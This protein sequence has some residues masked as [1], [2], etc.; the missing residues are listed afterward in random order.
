MTKGPVSELHRRW[1]PDNRL[2][3][4]PTPI[5]EIV[6]LELRYGFSLPQAFR[7]Y[8]IVGTP[9][10]Y[11]L[12]SDSLF[13]WWPV[14]EMCSLPDGYEH[15]LENPEILAEADRYLLF[16]DYLMWCWGYAICCSD[17]P[18]RG[19]VAMIAGVD[20]DPFIAESFTAFVQMHNT[21]PDSLMH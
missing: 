15:P 9:A 2:T 17:G 18:N 20:G 12:D 21:D 7:D 16:A 19:R 11:H 6:T 5:A 3:L 13:A 8:L 1:V 14:A 10:A 4:R